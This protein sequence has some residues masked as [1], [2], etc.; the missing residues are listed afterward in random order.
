MAISLKAVIREIESGRQLVRPADKRRELLALMRELSATDDDPHAHNMTLLKM[1]GL[2]DE[3]AFLYYDAMYTYESDVVA[4]LRHGGEAEAEAEAEAEEEEAEAEAEEEEAEEEEDEEEEEEEEE[5]YEGEDEEDALTS[6][7]TSVR[8]MSST[9]LMGMTT[10][11][12][13]TGIMNVGM[14]VLAGRV[15]QTCRG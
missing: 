6:L 11:L 2:D 3:V 15:L 8:T 9:L 10:C 1:T 12:L 4:R 5:E 7:E 14:L 13:I